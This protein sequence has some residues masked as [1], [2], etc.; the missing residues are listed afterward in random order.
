M[1][2]TGSNELILLGGGLLSL[3]LIS[4]ILSCWVGMPLLLAFLL[5][6]MMAG[7][8]GLRLFSFHEPQ[9][10]YLVSS[11]A[12][13]VILFEAGL[14]TRIDRFRM[15]AR[16]GLAL[17][18]GG[19]VITSA[20]TG[21]IAALALDVGI[22][23]GL[24][25]GAMVGS[26]DTSAVFS[27]LRA[28]G[29][30]V[31]PRVSAT[32]EVESGSN[33]PMAM[34]LTVVLVEILASHGDG[35]LGLMISGLIRQFG[36]GI[37]VGVSGS[38][39]ISW[40]VRRLHF[41]E[42]EH[43]PLLVLAGA[44]VVYGISGVI[45]GSGFLAIY[46]AGLILGNH[47]LP[48]LRSILHLHSGLAWLCQIGLFLML[49]LLADPVE[50]LRLALPAMV[51]AAGLMLLARPI[52][53]AICLAP[54]SFSWRERVFISWVGLRGAVPIVLALFP[55]LAGLPHS[56]IYLDIA[57]FL[58]IASLIFQGGSITPL[59]RRLGLEIPIV[60]SP[61][62][63]MEVEDSWGDSE[64]HIYRL[65]E[66][67]PILDRSYEC[68]ALPGAAI[69][70][71]IQREGQWIE[72][73]DIGRFHF[74]DTVYLLGERQE[75]EKIGPLLASVTLR[76]RAGGNFVHGDFLLHGHAPMH[77]LADLY[78]LPAYLLDR[79][80]KTLD[81]FLCSRLTGSPASGD[82]I[83]IGEVEFTIADVRDGHIHHAG[84]SIL[85][86]KATVKKSR[87]F[88]KIRR[89][90]PRAKSKNGRS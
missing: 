3:G 77:E 38:M 54:F 79:K 33:D 45:G 29:V 39:G 90:K 1:E 69:I 84:I 74:G 44:F 16:P 2:I 5:V 87:A 27:L 10:A 70:A 8:H 26:T 56:E 72:P 73:E 53:V 85:P 71:G 58:V 66:A 81:E 82:R 36:I 12:L 31:K 76:P 11:I 25:I 46:L 24:L 88:P 23:E 43:Y 28:R 75:L 6:G 52:A 83:R 4:S 41:T 64:L 51:I 86:P 34:V 7:E 48:N 67:S 35:G 21:I 57:F 47:H 30:R 62:Q 49:G 61:D 42:K 18:T 40:L 63:R 14:T 17:A 89:Y 37:A 80:E 22:V 55:Q 19:V 78:G 50:L 59:A 15:G 32:L 65:T 9:A 13:A 60:P 68:L 20:I